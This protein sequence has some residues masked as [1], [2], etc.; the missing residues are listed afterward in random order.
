MDQ[1]VG[2]TKKHP[3]AAYNAAGEEITS[4]TNVKGYYSINGETK[5]S[6]TPEISTYDSDMHSFYL[7]IPDIMAVFPHDSLQISL[8]ATEGTADI[9]INVIPDPESFAKASELASIKAITELLP[10][11]TEFDTAIDSIPSVSEIL[12]AIDNEVLDGTYTRIQVERILAAVLAGNRTRSGGIDTF[13]GLDGSTPR[14]ITTLAPDG[15][16][17]INRDGD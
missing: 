5:N 14:L 8:T 16:T 9:L 12:E 1:I 17:V 15:R 4:L 10:T 2:T 6:F 7:T 11:K 13:R 3:F